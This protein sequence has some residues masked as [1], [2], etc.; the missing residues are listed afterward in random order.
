[1]W[2][3][4]VVLGPVRTWGGSTRSRRWVLGALFTSRFR[5]TG[6]RSTTAPNVAEAMKLFHFSITYLTALFILMGG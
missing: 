2:A 5:S 6:T 4:T 3:V 1:M